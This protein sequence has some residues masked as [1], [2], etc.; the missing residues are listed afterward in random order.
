MGRDAVDAVLGPEAARA[1]PSATD[2]LR[3]VGAADRPDLDRLVTELVGRG[4][5]PTLADV[6]VA[7]HGTQAPDVLAFGSA[8]GLAGRL[9]PDVELLEAEVAW[10]VHAELALSVDDVLARRARLAQELPDRG[11]AI[12]PRVAGIM[13]TSLGWTAERQADE[14]AAYLTGAR[15]EYGVPEPARAPAVEPTP[16][17]EPAR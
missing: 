14:V 1:R 10:A 6:L 12:A 8:L 16:A 13:G 11:A 15:R 2:G 3:L 5:E 9:A 17:F 4:I 7:R